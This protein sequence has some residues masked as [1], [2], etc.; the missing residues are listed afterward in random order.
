MKLH[1][2][3]DSQVIESRKKYGANG[4]TEQ[5]S[6]SF[7]QKLIVNFNDPIIKILC[8]VLL[9]NVAFTFQRQNRNDYKRKT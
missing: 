9:I 5:S 8:V 4:I 2:L 6:E 3:T 1:G 7:F